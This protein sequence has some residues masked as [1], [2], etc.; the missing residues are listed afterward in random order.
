M[1][2]HTVRLKVSLIIAVILLAGAWPAAV[3]GEFLE[4]GA[5]EFADH[6]RREE[7]GLPSFAVLARE[8]GPTVVNVA[9]E[10]AGDE[11]SRPA[12]DD[13][14]FFGGAQPMR[15]LGSG[16]VVSGSGYIVT[17]N[18][19]VANAKR[20]VVKLLDN[21]EYPAT[22]V[23]RDE[24]TDLAL[25]KIEPKHALPTV[26]A[27][28]SARIEVG[29]WVLAIGHQFQLGQTVTAGIISAKSRR[30][31]THESGPYDDFIQTDA[32][33]NPGSSGGPLF[34]RRGQV[35]GITTAIFSPGRTQ[36]GGQGFN[37]GIGFAIPI[38]LART[39]LGQLKEKGRVTRG[40]LGIYI[41][42]I[43]AD[44]AEALSLENT[45]GALVSGVI[46]G[47]PAAAAGFQL[48]DVVQEYAGNK[49]NERDELPLLVA[50]TK[51][52]EKVVI[53][54]MRDG[55]P[56]LLT[57]VIAELT[58]NAFGQPEAKQ[59]KFDRAGLVVQ[60]LTDALVESL[61]IGERRG[62]LVAGVEPSSA[63]SR[64][65]LGRG[66]VIIEMNG[67]V[68]AN[69]KTYQKLLASLPENKPVLVLVRRREGARFVT[70]RVE[71]VSEN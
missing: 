19:V 3:V 7:S 4:E 56:K 43:D 57:P 58:D 27:G 11:Q 62:V 25:L 61:E 29:E 26:L 37:I 8:L 9:V 53:K 44:L 34:N 40:L 12:A 1:H 59:P 15:S 66:D 46:P 28:D 52:G 69:L 5:P 65:G 48:K 22:L 42:E 35:I 16:F 21:S 41:Q 14:P 55:K 39:V 67:Q 6:G 49:I 13:L 18:H 47:S 71:R 2:F 45:G 32:S 51:V 10:A 68:A 54:I 31:P 36:F 64:A 23:G 24:R 30:V 33:I 70:L 50:N 38:N 20:I 63:G 60:E 17:N